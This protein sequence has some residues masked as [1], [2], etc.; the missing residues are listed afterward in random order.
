MPTELQ[1]I[2]AR[3]GQFIES[4]KHALRE[5]AESAPK[6]YASA[7]NIQRVFRGGRSRKMIRNKQ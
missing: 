4:L 2:Q 7:Q 6:E 3:K 5:A 1:S